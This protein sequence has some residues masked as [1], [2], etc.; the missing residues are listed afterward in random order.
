MKF[1][2]LGFFRIFWS[3]NGKKRLVFQFKRSNSYSNGSI[4]HRH[5]ATA[6]RPQ[7]Q[8]FVRAVAP[9][10]VPIRALPPAPASLLCYRPLSSTVAGWA[11]PPNMHTLPP[12]GRAVAPVV[13]T[14][15]RWIASQYH[16]LPARGVIIQICYLL[17]EKA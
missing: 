17:I 9:G 4:T 6:Q 8:P 16:K 1:N 10:M 3:Y 12:L 11:V 5:I 15:L 13:R 2:S 7:R 14:S